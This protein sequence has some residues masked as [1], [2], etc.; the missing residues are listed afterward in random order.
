MGT[1]VQLHCIAPTSGACCHPDGGGGDYVKAPSTH[2]RFSLPTGRFPRHI[3]GPAHIDAI[4]ESV[5]RFSR[6]LDRLVS[7]PE[8]ILDIGSLN[9]IESV[10][11]SEHYPNTRIVCFEPVPESA[12]EVTWMCRS[13]KNVEVVEKAVADFDGASTFFVTTNR[14][15]SSLLR[16]LKFGPAHSKVEPRRIDVDVTRID[17]WAKAFKVER[18]DAVWMDVQG[19]EVPVLRGMGSL[20]SGVQVLKSEVSKIDYYEGHSGRH[21]TLAILKEY[22]LEPAFVDSASEYEDDMVFRRTSHSCAS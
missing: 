15:T 3:Q 1:F 19:A 21:E 12:E 5:T 7:S 13:C 16:P 2:S 20:L 11:L 9:G 4:C 10:L 17:T 6:E 8:V 22:G 18:V 14:G